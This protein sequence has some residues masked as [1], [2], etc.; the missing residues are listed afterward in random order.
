[1]PAYPFALALLAGFT[2]RL[3]TRRPLAVLTGLAL[4]LEV[5]LFYAPLWSELPL[6]EAAFNARLFPFWR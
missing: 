5:S 1:L 2:D 3:Y 6:S 4:V